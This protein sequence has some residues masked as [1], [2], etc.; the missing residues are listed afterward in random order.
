MNHLAS[1]LKQ[2]PYAPSWK[3]ARAFLA[4]RWGVTPVIPLTPVFAFGLPLRDPENDG[5]PNSVRAGAADCTGV[6]IQTRY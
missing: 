2:S 4:Q 6:Q 1:W 3:G 5:G